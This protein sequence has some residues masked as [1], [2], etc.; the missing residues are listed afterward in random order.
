MAAAC[1]VVVD[2]ARDRLRL[3]RIPQTLE[4]GGE[5]LGGEQVEQHQHIGLLGGLVPIRRV[6]FGLEDAVQAMDVA[7]ALT[8]AGPV[9]LGQRLVALELADEAVGVKDHAQPA[10][11]LVPV[12]QLGVGQGQALAQLEAALL[13]QQLQQLQRAPQ[14]PGGHHAGIGMVVQTRLVRPRVRGLELVGSDD[15]TDLVAPQRLVEARDAGPEAGDLEEDFS[16]VERQELVVARGLVVLPDVVGDR[17]VDMPLQVRR[18]RRPPARARIQ[19][20]PLALLATIAAALPRVHRAGVAG[21]RRVGARGAEPSVAVHQQR[22]CDVG[23]AQVE[24]RKDE[25][26]VPEDMPPVGLA[27]PAARRYTRV[28]MD[29]VQRRR[30]QQVE[31]VKSQHARR[32]AGLAAFLHVDVEAPPQLRPRQRVAGQQGVEPIRRGHGLPGLQSA[33]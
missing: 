17:R 31:D 7:V 11:D 23:Q 20:H 6:A 21:V 28:K 13:G 30:L 14:H 29:G 12:R 10:A 27:V 3:E 32:T 8:V 22:A 24:Q 16:A 18:I 9:E 2:V 5:L 4:H 1:G 15:A 19:V 25:Q 33:L 26:F